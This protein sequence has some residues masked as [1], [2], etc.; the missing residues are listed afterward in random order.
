MSDDEIA[1]AMLVATFRE[2]Q[3][4]LVEGLDLVDAQDFDRADIHHLL[5]VTRNLADQAQALVLMMRDCGADEAALQY[6]N[7]LAAF[8]WTTEDRI[9]AKLELGR[10]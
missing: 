3:N 1:F 9:E 5:E 6:A 4:A 7:D 10:A 8:L 2:G